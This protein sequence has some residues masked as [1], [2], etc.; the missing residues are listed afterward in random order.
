MS[1]PTASCRVE[2][3]AEVNPSED[4]R[5]V[6][7]AVTNMT[8]ECECVVA[9][10][11]IRAI[12]DDIASLDTL[13]D[14]VISRQSQAGLSRNL[15][16]NLDGETAW[17]YL[18]RQAALVGAAAVCDD[19]EESP[20]GPLRITITSNHIQDIIGWMTGTA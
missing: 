6:Q 11:S 2:V 9:G 8:P 5:K 20:L 18:N 17:F 13:R 12:S 19:P 15:L 4:P 16:R 10:S 3:W 1:R 7:R 14:A